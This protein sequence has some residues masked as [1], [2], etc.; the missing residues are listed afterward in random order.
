MRT[1]FVAALL[2]VGCKGKAEEKK[3]EAPPP[4]AGSGAGSGSGSATTK[5]EA[6]KTPPEDPYARKAYRAGMAKGRKATDKKQWAEAIAGFDEALAAKKGDP[7]ALGERGFAKL[8]EGKDLASASRDLDQAATG[9]K[10][11]KLLSSI[12]FNRG[13]I[14]EKRGNE[15]NAV[16]AFV[17][18][19]TLR[20]TD[21]A[22]KK[23]EGKSACPIV[24]SDTL[25][26][27]DAPAAAAADW[28]ALAKA[29]PGAEL[30]TLKTK[31]D[32]LVWLTGEKT[33]PKLPAIVVANDYAI[34]VPYL[35]LPGG[36]GLRAMPL[37]NAQGGRCP[38]TVGF[39]IA[40]ASS[41]GRILVSGTEQF[42]GGYTFMCQGKG[43]E[44]V[45]CSDAPGEVSAGTACFGGTPTRR[46]IV[47]DTKAAKVI[48]VYEQPDD[49]PATVA[50]DSKGVKLA[51]RGC[52]RV[53]A[54]P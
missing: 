48:K 19:N 44:L 40:G 1:W 10:D 46:D 33:E 30:D 26:V 20:P 21:A 5:K 42:D 36:P 39:D 18:A 6:P 47:V 34:K 27:P 24:V 8:L 15:A 50:L 14:E 9:T 43:D 38:G 16:A 51:G 22:R 29:L 13:L 45:E 11:P 35:V 32:A 49:K 3:V 41:D 17:I 2:V 28:L 25:E 23:I 4:A 31:D 37:G 12:W 52:D 53:D 7:R 54:L